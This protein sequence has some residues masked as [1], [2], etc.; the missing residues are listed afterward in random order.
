MLFRS[1]RPEETVIVGDSHVDIETGRNAGLWTLGVSY[2]FAP[3]TLQSSPP[4][5]SVDSAPEVAE[6]FA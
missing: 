5:V 1:V 3:H 6:V 2:G 4:D